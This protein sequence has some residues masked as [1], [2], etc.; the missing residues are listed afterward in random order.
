MRHAR[1]VAS[2]YRES[3]SEAQNMLNVL[4]NGI[5]W[6]KIGEEK[7]NEVHEK[8]PKYVRT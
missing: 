4:T 7:I 6:D 3:V 1:D 2:A 5:D 8:A